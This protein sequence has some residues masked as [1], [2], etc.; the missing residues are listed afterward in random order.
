[1][2]SARGIVA[3]R[4]GRQVLH[5]IDVD[6][7]NGQVLV[8]VGANGS[9]KSTLLRVL[10]GLLAPDQG[11]VERAGRCALALQTPALTSRSARSNVIEALRWWGVPRTERTA[12][13]TRSLESL[14]ASSFADQRSGTLSGGQ[15]RRVHLAR[16][17]AVEAE[18]LMLDEPFAGLDPETRG[19]LLYEVGT[20]LRS[21]DRATMLVLQDLGEA[22]ALAD[23]LAV[24]VDGRLVA[25]GAPREL[26]ERPP[27]PEVARF[28]GYRGRLSEGGRTRFLRSSDVRLDPSGEIEARVAH[29][30]PIEDG[31][32]LELETER[33]RVAAHVPLPGPQIGE[34]VRLS[35]GGGVLFDAATA[36]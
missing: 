1:V 6:A 9:G 24:M 17:L 19:D 23:R 36:E 12:R 20:L 3:G 16:A 26:F 8:I 28:F 15:A 33:G 13:A 30:I 27:T 25:E 32:R 11:H 35:I 22:L 31:V 18:T 34:V 10:A 21:E 7:P 29:T 5:G 2:I 14:G 4:G